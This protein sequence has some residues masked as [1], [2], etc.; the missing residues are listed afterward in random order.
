LIKAD[1]HVH[2]NCSKDCCTT[3]D[4][5]IE[6]CNSK[7]INCLAIADHG[8]IDGAMKVSELAPFKVII[9]EEVLTPYGE[10]MGMFLHENIP[11]RIDL[12][13]AIKLIKKQGGI[14]C[15]PHPYDRVRPSALSNTSILNEISDLVDIVEIFNARSMYPFAEKKAREY[16]TKYGK[17][18]SAGSDAHSP[19]EVGQ[20]Y[21]EMAD[22]DSKEAFMSSL[23]EAKVC[24]RKSSPLIHLVSTYN[25]LKNRRG[26]R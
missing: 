11:H 17:V 14:V 2:T 13:E 19:N 8:T 24:G 26:R 7:S 20:V 23:A 12:L 6:V 22:F 15:I 5:L 4:Q 18:V 1:L 21:L 3:F 16:A 10:I 9:C 25:S